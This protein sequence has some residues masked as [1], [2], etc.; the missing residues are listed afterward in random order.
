MAYCTGPYSHFTSLPVPPRPAIHVARG[1][2]PATKRY[3]MV[4]ETGGYE[5]MRTV[6]QRVVFLVAFNVPEAKYNT[7]NEHNET[8]LQIRKA[9]KIMVDDKDI[10]IISVDVGSNELGQQYRH[11]NYKDLTKGGKDETV[12][13]S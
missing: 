1:Y 8:E 7:P 13:L 4:E 5:S 6:A 12:Q 11:I 2:N 3:V 10:E 9:L